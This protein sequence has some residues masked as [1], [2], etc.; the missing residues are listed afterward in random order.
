VPRIGLDP[1]YLPESGAD[2]SRIRPLQAAARGLPGAP[3]VIALEHASGCR[4]GVEN[5]VIKGIDRDEREIV[6]P[7]ESGF[8]VDGLFLSS[9]LQSCRERA[10]QSSQNSWGVRTAV[11]GSLP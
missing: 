1:S 8:P 7:R 4:P 10:S 3:F 5:P 2:R 6:A 11:T 9:G